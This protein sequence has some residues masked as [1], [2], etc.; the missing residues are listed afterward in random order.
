MIPKKTV[1]TKDNAKY[2]K[3]NIEH[4]L[5]KK[6]VIDNDNQMLLGINLIEGIIERELIWVTMTN[7]DPSHIK[8]IKDYL[9]QMKRMLK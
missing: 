5:L 2:M 9:R 3:L 4:E 6:K 8:K 7:N 1:M